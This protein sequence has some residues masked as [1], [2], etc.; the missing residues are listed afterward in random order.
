[1]RWFVLFQ[2]PGTVTFK[3]IQRLLGYQI[4]EIDRSEGKFPFIPDVDIL[5]NLNL[6]GFRM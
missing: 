3:Y 4:E 6:V 1:M 5:S 2:S